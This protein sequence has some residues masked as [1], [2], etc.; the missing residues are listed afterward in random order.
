MTACTPV[1]AKLA[2][3]ERINRSHVCRVL[4]LTPDIV[5]RILD[6]QRTADLGHFLKPFPLEWE[7]QREWLS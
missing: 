5:D 4:R 1:L 2:D 7:R 6:G 3:A